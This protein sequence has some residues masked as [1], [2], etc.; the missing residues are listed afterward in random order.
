MVRAFPATMPDEYLSVRSWNEH[1]E[2]FECGMIRTMSEWSLE[3]QQLMRELLARRY[4][5]RKIVRVMRATLASGYLTLLVETA[6]GQE[7]IVMRWTQ[8]QALDYGHHGKLIIDSREN[9]Y[10]VEDVS[11]LPF[12]DRE[13]FLQYIYW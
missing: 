11:V 7:E 12:E 13:R 4:L 2:E 6:D 3:A 8:S 5:L 9:R 1:G 10:V